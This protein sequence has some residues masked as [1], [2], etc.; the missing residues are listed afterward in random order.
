MGARHWSYEDDEFLISYFDAVGDYV[1]THDLG[2]PKGAATRRVAQLKKCGAWDALIRKQ[3]LEAK[4]GIASLRAEL[5]YAKALGYSIEETG[6]SDDEA[7]APADIYE[8]NYPWRSDPFGEEAEA[9][10]CAGIEER[11]EML[12]AL[13]QALSALAMMVAPE[14]ISNSSVANA[15]S[16][17]VEAETKVRAVIKRA[18][19][20]P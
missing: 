15:W 14:A 16:Q 17:A 18:E 11:A 5:D 6:C 3:Q 20:Q 2:R 13:K 10:Q 7:D 1:G 12:A 8:G 9:E 4:A 19:A